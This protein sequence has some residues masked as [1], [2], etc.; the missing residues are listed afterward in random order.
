MLPCLQPR[1]VGLTHAQHPSKLYLSELVLHAIADDTHSHLVCEM[2][3][4]PFRPVFR[5]IEVTAVQLLSCLEISHLH[6]LSSSKRCVASVT[7]AMA[8]SRATRSRAGPLY[9]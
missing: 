9:R 1:D 8:R 2:G 4:L 5:I 7:M 3:S 6:L